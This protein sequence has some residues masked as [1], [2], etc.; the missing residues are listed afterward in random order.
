MKPAFALVAI[1][2]LVPAIF[3][4]R[5]P[6]SPAQDPRAIAANDYQ[7]G[8]RRLD[9]IEKLH[10]DRAAA[11]D[12]KSIEKISRNIQK[13]L[14]NAAADFKRAV[15][16]DPN[17]FAAWSELGFCLRKLGRFDESL[18]AYDR[19]LQIQPAFSPAIEYR[20]EAYLALNRLE[21]ARE[22]YLLLFAGDRARA[23]ILL[24]AMKSWVSERRADPGAIA[25]EK[26]DQFADWVSKREI[27]HQQTG[28]VSA[29]SASRSW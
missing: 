2:L 23:G 24:E 20:A 28:S 26:I 17:H 8:S 21:E 19:A 9:K 11:S 16:N 6:E 12:P 7:S 14:E 4:A 1:L 29:T 5:V 25:A 15:R 13:Q 22:A 10:K 3:A 18:A 27:F